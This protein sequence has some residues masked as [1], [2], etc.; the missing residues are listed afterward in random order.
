MKTSAHLKRKESK[1]KYSSLQKTSFIDCGENI[2]IEDIKGE[3]NEEESV[4]DPLSIRRL[5]IVIS[6]KISRKRLERRP[7][8]FMILSL[9]RKG[10]EELKMK[11]FIQL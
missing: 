6:V 3:I 8:V 5:K 2:K 4:D 10:K 9:F 11:T 7:R 1:K